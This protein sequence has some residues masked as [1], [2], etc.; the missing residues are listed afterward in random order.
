MKSTMMLI[1]LAFLSSHTFA[2]VSQTSHVG[3]QHQL[4]HLWYAIALVPVA[5]LIRK[6]F[7][8]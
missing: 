7:S 6:I 5:L 3:Q 4:E 1:I 8:K 2:H